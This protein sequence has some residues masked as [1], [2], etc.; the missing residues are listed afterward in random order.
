MSRDALR[1]AEQGCGVGDELENGHADG[2]VETRIF[3]REMRSIGDRNADALLCHGQNGDV[4]ID[5]IHMESSIG[6]SCREVTGSTTDVEDRRAAGKWSQETFEHHL[7]DAINQRAVV[8]RIPSLVT[9]D[10][11]SCSVSVST[12]SWN[13][14]IDSP[15]VVSRGGRTSRAVAVI[16]G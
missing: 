2:G 12:S 4:R 5:S 8:R 15:A 14:W 1:F 10:L 16:S 6:E 13:R 11:G 3:E 9:R 7:L